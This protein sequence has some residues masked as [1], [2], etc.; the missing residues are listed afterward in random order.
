MRYRYSK[1][2]WEQAVSISAFKLTVNNYHRVHSNNRY[3]GIMCTKNPKS[4]LEAERKSN[5]LMTKHL[6]VPS[7]YC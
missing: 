7:L 5:F 4:A 3:I 1:V 6:T 2:V